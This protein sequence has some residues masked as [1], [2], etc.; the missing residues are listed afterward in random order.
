MN[1]LPWQPFTVGGTDHASSPQDR[2]AILLSV[3]NGE[4]YLNQQLDSFLAQ[5]RQDWTLYWRDDGS[6][7]SSRAIMLSFA[8]HRG[9]G[10]CM[11][12]PGPDGRIGIAESFLFL[13]NTIPDHPLIAFSDQD[14]VWIPE[15]LAWAAHA[16][17]EHSHPAL[18]CARQ[19]LTDSHLKILKPSPPLRRAPGFPA[20][21]TQNIATG[22]TVMLNRAARHLM[23]DF[24]PPPGILHDWWAYLI[25]SGADGTVIAD[26]R[27]VT[28]Y[29]QHSLNAVGVRSS[30]LRR[31]LAALHR[32]PG[33]FMALFTANLNRLAIRPETLTPRNHQL[34][35]RLQTACTTGRIA[36]LNALRA[37]PALIRQTPLETLLFRL[38][39]LR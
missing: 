32:G 17:T 22:H 16:L 29:R 26:P 19:Y 25:V 36:R 23:Q 4:A 39:F 37:C 1:E 21:L 7:D 34:L 3:H 6:T 20:A 13:L 5:T 31:G 27:C 35:T 38:W 11:E 24:P 12:L 2:I 8:T 10:R 14:D 18:Y 28:Y 30:F 15:K 9:K 33:A